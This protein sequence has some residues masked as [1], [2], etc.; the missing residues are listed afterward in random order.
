MTARKPKT[1]KNKRLKGADNRKAERQ[2]LRAAHM[3][4]ETAPKPQAPPP[5]PLTLPKR[6]TLPEGVTGAS[7]EFEFKRFV[8]SGTAAR[9]IGQVRKAHFTLW[10][11]EWKGLTAGLVI[12]LPKSDS[13]TQGQIK[14]AIEAASADLMPPNET[15][16]YRHAYR[17]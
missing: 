4:R 6:I 15:P 7:F 8:F 16:A 12:E 3:G 9:K 5:P 11:T 1:R 17:C 13:V 2:T 14:T 10:R